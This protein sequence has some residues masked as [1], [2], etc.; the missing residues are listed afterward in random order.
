MQ[1]DQRAFR[2]FWSNPDAPLSLGCIGCLFKPECG[3]QTTAGAGFN[4]LD[5]CC[6]APETCQVV[7]PR[8][9]VFIDRCREV[10]GF[11]LNTPCA[12]PVA[13]PA[14]VPYMPLIFHGSG[15]VDRLAAPAVAI[16]LYRFFDRNADSR[17]SSLHAV[18]DAFRIHPGAKLFLSGVAQDKEVERWWKLEHRGRIKAI[19]NLRRLGVSLVTTPNFSLM[20]DRPRTDDLHSMKRIVQVH[21]EFIS[22]GQAAALHVNGRAEHD[23]ERWGDYIAAHPEVTHL[24]YEFTTGTRNPSRM[25]QHTKWLAMLASASPKRLGLVLRGGTYAIAELARYFDISVIDSSPFSKA[26]RRQVAVLSDDGQRWWMKHH[27]PEGAPID[28][29]LDASLRVSE[30]WHRGLLSNLQLAA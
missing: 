10:R 9:S 6:G 30:Q 3:G 8:A 7:C 17:F 12:E 27:T 26:Q 1:H 22:E 21:H 18:C 23:F 5:H 15:R 2:S 20:V 11:A 19:A 4:C 29:L 16:P 14:Y 28:L 24:A 25:Q 13:G